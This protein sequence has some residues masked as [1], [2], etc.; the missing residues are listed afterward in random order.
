MKVIQLGPYPPPHGGV[1]TNLKAI[2][3]RLIELGH[4]AS[5]I[6]LT[7]ASRT[8]GDPRVHKPSSALQ[9]FRL[10]V[11]MPA[12]VLHFHVGG[13][14]T[15]RLAL[16]MILCGNLPRRRAVVTFHSGGYAREAVSYAVPRSLRG[17]AFRSVDK[18]VAVNAQMTEMLRRFGVDDGKISLIAPHSI[19][20]PPVNA[21]VPERIA[22]FVRDRDPLIISVNG[23]ER[24]Y[25]LPLQIEAMARVLDRFPNSGLLILGWGS[26]EEELGQIIASKTYAEHILLAG[27]VDRGTAM[28]LMEKADLMLRTTL[29]D[30][31]AVSVREA[32]FLGTPVLATDTGMRPDGVHL[33]PEDPTP[34]ALATRI[35]EVLEVP[36][37]TP[38][39]AEK[40]DGIENIDAVIRLYESLVSER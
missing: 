35:A 37:I 8:N 40:S 29:Y 4:D 3:H 21:A 14:F 17:T 15:A 6:A 34:D 26:L 12:D 38:A 28:T 18:V 24:E 27:D 32:L 33:I 16:L 39:A 9:L 25:C 1:Q 30:G 36:R 11:S 20:A 10:L 13:N 22:E 19:V 7:R 5:V 31:D 2:H 23:L